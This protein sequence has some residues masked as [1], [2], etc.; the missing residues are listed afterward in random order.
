M[1]AGTIPGLDLGVTL[2][3]RPGITIAGTTVLGITVVGM[4]MLTAT[5]FMTDIIPV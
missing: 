3:I 4:A 5:V 2:G 1:A